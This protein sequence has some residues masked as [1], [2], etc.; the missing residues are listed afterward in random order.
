MIPALFDGTV[1]VAGTAVL[2]EAEQA[3]PVA[4]AGTAP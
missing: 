2:R 4:S 3:E 1:A